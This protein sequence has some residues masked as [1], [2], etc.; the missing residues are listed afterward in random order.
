MPFPATNA[1]EPHM[2]PQGPES[3]LSVCLSVCPLSSL[4]GET[5]Q[6]AG[7]KAAG[8]A[9]MLEMEGVRVPDGFVVLPEA[10]TGL[11]VVREAILAEFDGL[12]TAR[13]AVR[14][15]GLRE[16]GAVESCAGMF[17]TFLDVDRSTLL[18]RIEEVRQSALI[19]P[20]G[21]AQMTVVVQPMLPVQ[22]GGVCFSMS[23]VGRSDELLVEA[24]DGLCEAL[25][26]G[27]VTPERYRISRTTLEIRHDRSGVVN[28]G[29]TVMSPELL[30]ELTDVAFRLEQM[31]GHAVDIEWALAFGVL[32]ILQCRPITAVAGAAPPSEGLYRYIWSTS[33]PLWMMELGVMTRASLL[34]E[35]YGGDTLWDLAD[36]FYA[37]QG[38][39]Y[40]YYISEDDLAR[41]RPK[42]SDMQRILHKAE[43]AQRLQDEF[44]ASMQD[45]SP[46]DLT[47]LEL[48][49]FLDRAARFYCDHIGLYSASSSLVT[50]A[51]EE[52]LRAVLTIEE[53]LNLMRTFEP[54]LMETE[55]SD[56]AILVSTGRLTREIAL[57]HVRKYPFIALNLDSE[58]QIVAILESLY[59]E[60]RTRLSET[61][62]PDGQ[63]R[64]ALESEQAKILRRHPELRETVITLHRMSA[65]RMRIKRGWAGLGFFMIPLLDEVARRSGEPV[66]EILA[67]YRFREIERLILAGERL[68]AAT[69]RRR[70]L[71]C[72]WHALD[73]EIEFVDG[74][75]ANEA[76]DA[77]RPTPGS[78][79]LHGF[80]ASVGTARGRAR[81]VH[82][83]DPES[84]R[85]ARERFGD[86]DILVTEM[87]QPGMMDLIA[88]SGAV[89]T[90]E[91]GLLSH[92]AIVTREH[93]I[94][95]VVGT[96]TAT[97]ELV[98][99]EMIELLPTGEI[100]RIEDAA[101]A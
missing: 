40:E 78:D 12:N 74:E 75:A 37:K 41:F 80:I 72:L 46:P 20:G 43:E 67:H 76:I 23:P 34:P 36:I 64:S 25:V 26:S 100:V 35:G 94:P 6:R 16:D 7:G 81:I 42:T 92:A 68:D 63:S 49:S 66:E 9:R 87:A 2:M 84:T 4:T 38:V 97:K 61:D 22:I 17:R 39:I 91:G 77:L 70:A 69:K 56:W 28:S 71:A 86:G 62:A 73:G 60:S 83:N 32:H 93:G 21:E 1:D 48:A 30:H 50:R 79:V 95:C 65:S 27:E 31:E 51:L 90:D 89:V 101:E 3:V 57:E 19:D 29:R 13:V 24:V 98:D 88:R 55:Q 85:L 44:F 45:V 99:G 14:S 96:G 58:A 33:E 8:L 5:R 52:E 59:E 47:S 11:P 53:Q 18:E 15:S 54:D 10:A 82:C